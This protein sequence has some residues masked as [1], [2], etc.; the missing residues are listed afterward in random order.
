MAPL[1]AKRHYIELARILGQQVQDRDLFNRAEISELVERL[2]TAFQRDNP[3]FKPTVFRSAV[4]R[5][6]Q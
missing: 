5:D 4:W 2:C 1:F 3:A 6:G